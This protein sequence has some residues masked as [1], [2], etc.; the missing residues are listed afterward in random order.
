MKVADIEKYRNVSKLDEEKCLTLIQ[1][2]ELFENV[3]V[4]KQGSGST[5]STSLIGEI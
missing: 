2:P 1:N 5:I 4:I 3:S